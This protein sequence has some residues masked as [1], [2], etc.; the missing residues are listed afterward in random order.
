MD[1]RRMNN[2][3]EI[4]QSLIADIMVISD[5]ESQAIAKVFGMIKEAAFST[6]QHRVIYRAIKT[7]ATRGDMI[8]LI[9]IDAECKKHEHYND[10]FFVYLAQVQRNVISSANIMAHARIMR[11][12]A[13][14]RFAIQKLHVY[15]VIP[16]TFFCVSSNPSPSR[17]LSI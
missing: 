13:I 1:G 8:D 10:D 4:E 7:I 3:I 2:T 9:T 14:E 17:N 11:E 5:P 16:S 15:P 6:L 12:N